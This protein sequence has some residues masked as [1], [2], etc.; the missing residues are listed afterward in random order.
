MVDKMLNV[1]LLCNI[2]HG[3]RTVPEAFY[4]IRYVEIYVPFSLFHSGLKTH[5]FHKCFSP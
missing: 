1:S 2:L 4:T 5:L 3:G